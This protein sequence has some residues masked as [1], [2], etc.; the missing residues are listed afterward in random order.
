MYLK[1]ARG[2]KVRKFW[3]FNDGTAEEVGLG[4]RIPDF[5]ELFIQL[6]ETGW[7]EVM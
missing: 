6:K 3:L 2:N 7:N 5:A 4:G 1:M